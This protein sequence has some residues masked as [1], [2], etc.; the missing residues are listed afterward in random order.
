MQF[1]YKDGLIHWL[2]QRVSAIFMLVLIICCFDN[3]FTFSLVFIIL[4]YHV[5]VGIET[6]LN[7]YIHNL[8]LLLIGYTFLRIFILFLFK[9]LLIICL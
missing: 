4:G 8:N 1:F 3:V 9:I 2:I 5:F 6:L 7:D